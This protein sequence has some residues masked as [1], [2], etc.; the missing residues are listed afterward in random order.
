M[1]GVDTYY[2]MAGWTELVNFMQAEI[3]LF[4]NLLFELFSRHGYLDCI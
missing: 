4:L 3:V 1:N 2:L